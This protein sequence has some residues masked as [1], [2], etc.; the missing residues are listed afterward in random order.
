[1]N[2]P[3]LVAGSCSK[4]EANPISAGS[5]GPPR[6][7]ARI[8]DLIAAGPTRS[9]EFFPPRS[10]AGERELDATLRGLAGLEPSFASVTYGALGSTRSRTRELVVRM[11]GSRSFPTMP[12]L[13]CVGHTRGEIRALLDDYAAR[14]V[15]NILA[16][17]GDPPS[18]GSDPGGAFRHAIDLVREIRRHPAGFCVGV[19]AHP[20][21]H[22]RSPDRAS[23]IRHLARKL[24]LADFAIT[25]FF[26]DVRLYLRLVEDLGALGCHRPV[27]PGVMPVTSL[28]GLTRMAAVNRTDIP[29]DLLAR[30]RSAADDA[31]VVDIGVDAATRLA[32]DLLAAGAPGVHIYTL[33]RAAP[34]R[35]VWEALG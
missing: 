14:G 17:G 13:T 3:L 23:D 10:D 11:N 28:A 2:E 29:A 32:A 6:A 35:R 26:F 34:A 5:G 22:P 18:D 31:A 20:E 8:A 15:R 7:A 24:E 33:N 27:L 19:A 9:L 1:M 4:D 16:L 25:Q 30:L 21:V 12:H